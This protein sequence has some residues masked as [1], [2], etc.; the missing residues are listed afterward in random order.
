[1]LSPRLSSLTRRSVI[2][3]L[4]CL[5]FTGVSCLH[6]EAARRRDQFPAEQDVF[7]LPQPG[8]L[9][10][11]SLGHTE[12]MAD[13][14]WIRQVLFFSDQMNG[15]GDLQWLERCLKAIV[16]LDPRFRR[17]Y[18]W[19]GVVLVYGGTK[20]T[21]REVRQSNEFLELGLKE[22]PDDWELHFMLGAN[23][24]NELKTSDK[25]LKDEW[26]MRGADHMRRAALSGK[27]APWVP[28]L[29]ATV[30]QRGG[31]TH[32][33]IR[34]LEE[35]LLTTDDETMRQHVRNKLLNLR[36]TALADME[37]HRQEFRRRWQAQMPYARSDLFVLFG[38]EPRDV[39]TPVLAIPDIMRVWEQAVA[40]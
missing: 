37:R 9:R 19:A 8:A 17:V 27:S 4:I 24:L 12:L 31:E 30:L 34:H 35:V 2:G 7:Y 40:E 36:A 33:A 32:A 15:R 28:V 39:E 22:F 10:A 20:V 1:M 18:S 14:V 26:R 29:V 3:I 13:L 5:A 11:A 16:A 21:N 38:D 6:A 23:Y 25:R